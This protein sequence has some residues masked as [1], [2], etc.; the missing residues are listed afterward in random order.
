MSFLPGQLATHYLSDS[1]HQRSHCSLYRSE[2][3]LKTLNPIYNSGNTV[4]NRNQTQSDRERKGWADVKLS[5]ALKEKT[6]S[7]ETKIYL[8]IAHTGFLSTWKN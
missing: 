4:S 1:K 6:E 5:S 3:R 7:T 8:Q 2:V